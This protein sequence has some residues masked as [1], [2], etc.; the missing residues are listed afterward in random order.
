MVYFFKAVAQLLAIFIKADFQSLNTSQSTYT[1]TRI[2]AND[3]L[4]SPEQN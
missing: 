1:V 2:F 3:R 4:I